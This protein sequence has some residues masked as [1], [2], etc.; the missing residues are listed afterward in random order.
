MDNISKPTILPNPVILHSEELLK[1]YRQICCTF[2]LAINYI[3]F[4]NLY[5]RKQ[6]FM[7]QYILET[8]VYSRE[9]ETLKE[10]RNATASHPM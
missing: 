5:T 7:L 8:S 1:V 9:P 2:S 3:L 4:L 6:L 10:L